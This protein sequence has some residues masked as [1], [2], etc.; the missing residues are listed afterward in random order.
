MPFSS[1]TFSLY[2]PGNPVV[3]GTTI[4]SDTQNNTMND[5]ATGLST[6]VLKDGT[7]TM[8]A[9]IP[10]NSFKFTGLAAGTTAGDSIR[11]EQLTL[12]T[13]GT[14]QSTGSGT[15]VT[16]TGIPSWAKNIAVIFDGL[17]SDTAAVEMHL[18]TS[19]G[20]EYTGY[21]T[22]SVG[23]DATPSVIE[24]TTNFQIT[25]PFEAAGVYSG[26]I[27]FSLKNASTF[28]W[29]CMGMLANTGSTQVCIVAGRKSTASALDRLNIE[30]PA[31]ALD[32][33]T[34]NIL[35]W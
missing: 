9:N 19:S 21:L 16:F 13:N 10:M 30:V 34:V 1:G 28:S 4:S 23:V 6:C 32:A 29:G 33:G 27:L 2:T 14:Q 8:T 15:S 25:E 7:Q 31:G 35:Y 26:T 12:A 3:S 22:S 20:L 11:Y 17:S 5:I 24:P 18:G